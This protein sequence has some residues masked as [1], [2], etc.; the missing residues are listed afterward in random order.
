MSDSATA[1]AGGPGH[2]REPR[3]AWRSWGVWVGAVGV[4]LLFVAVSVQRIWAGDFWGQLRTGQW[5]LEHGAVPRVDEYSFTRA[6][7]PVVEVRWLYCVVVALGWRVG[8]WVLCVG[9]AV[10][11]AGM[12]GMIVWPARRALREP[13]G[14]LVLAL[15]IGAGAGRWVLRPELATDFF[16]A[17]FLVGM[18]RVRWCARE[19]GSA[20]R[21]SG[22]WLA[23]AQ[24]V[25]ANT[26]SVYVMGPVVVGA[27][28]MGEVLEDVWNAWR[29]RGAGASEGAGDREAAGHRR[30]MVRMTVIGVVVGA[31][32]LVNPYGWRG[33][34]YA[35]EMWRETG[36]V[37]G[38]TIGEM[39]SPLAMPWGAWT[40]D[41]RAA[42]AL[43]AVAAVTFVWNWRRVGA[44]RVLV[45]AAA[46]Y[47]A[48][49]MQR[50][51]V[52]LAVM[53]GWAGL[54]NVAEAVGADG[55]ARG[56]ASRW[57]AVGAAAVGVVSAGLA[58]YVASDRAAIAEGA[59][60]EFGLG[61][62][63]WDLP[64][65]ATDFVVESGAAPQVF[66]TMR[67][68]HYIGWRS[69][70]RIKVFVDGR[71]DVYGDAF[72]AENAAIGPANWES[73]TERWGINTAIVPVKGYGD[74]L[75]FLSRSPDWMLVF[76]DHH[77][78]VFVRNVAAN[79]GV[80]EKYRVDLSRPWTPRGPEPY[81]AVEGWKAAIGGRGRPWYSL[82]MA[83]AFLAMR[84]WGNAKMYLERAAAGFPWSERARAEL[85]AVDRF[86]GDE[87]EGERLVRGLRGVW[88]GYS[89][90]TLASMLMGAGRKEE[91]LAA[92]ER[93]VRAEP[94]DPNAHV[95]LGDL[96]FQAQDFAGA[97]R[98]YEAAARDGHDAAAEWLKLG[99]ARER[100]GDAAAAE[101]AYRRSLD[102]D[103]RQAQVWNHLGTLV[104]V[105]DREAGI[106]CFER[107]VEIDPAMAAARRNLEAARR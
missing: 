30:A 67:A 72:L 52:L 38:E 12:W 19:G 41:L 7:V 89:E 71:T 36:S 85:S 66:N 86:L 5:I 2:R 42:G 58:W 77:D 64:T 102:R 70:G 56:S 33:A 24:V 106:R 17:A 63:E 80:I 94:G 23:P 44:A 35:A 1:G 83:E 105:H 11:L 54:M 99:Y 37:V 82:G 28:W 97:R 47:L 87:G 104:V 90:R 53:G 62:V 49:S 21:W 22:W 40:W 61:V 14:L 91:A 3:G 101:A 76:L 8:A 50:N 73:E 75:G 84:S 34:V 57:R 100:V 78:A 26:H 46:A 55:A 6:G 15:A 65:G 25:W 43:A 51:E 88:L 10:V 31:A 16:V 13:A 92:L 68:G 59:P 18:E 29:R 74:L 20:G 81:E 39:R 93:A 45:F 32:C 27:F 103:P 69:G 98:E 60:K 79:S 95:A 48:A 9:Q 96:L 107:A 4:V